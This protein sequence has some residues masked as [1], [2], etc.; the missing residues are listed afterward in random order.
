MS[1]HAH[2]RR[3]EEAVTI[4]IKA[5][6]PPQPIDD[7]VATSKEETSAHISSVTLSVNLPWMELKVTILA[8]YLLQEK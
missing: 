5:I 2:H 4:S 3:L 1:I 8:V 6:I 7:T